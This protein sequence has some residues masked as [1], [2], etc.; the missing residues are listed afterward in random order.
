MS[1][2]STT[3]QS[4][5]E[6]EQAV[7]MA[8]REYGISTTLFRNAVGSQL[9]VNATD[10]ECLAVLFFKGIATPTELSKYTGLTSGA[11]T[12]MLDRLER[13]GLIARQPNPNDRRG[14]LITVN[15]SSQLSV[16]PLFAGTRQAQDEL[17]SGYSIEQLQLIADFLTSLTAVWETSRQKLVG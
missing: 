13:A 12:A 6:L 17:V 9:G 15:K 1:T 11:T 8:A 16:G 3:N 4:K 5:A 14:V 10:M 7:K 2:R